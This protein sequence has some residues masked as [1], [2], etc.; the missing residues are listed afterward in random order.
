MN[1]SKKALLNALFLVITLGVNT[2]GAL[3]YINGLSQKAIS[4]MYITLITPSPSTFSIWG[5]IY[6]LLIVSI[7]VLIIKQDD[8]YY[9]KVIDKI[10][11]L[12]W[13][14]CLLN[15]AWIV[16][17]SYVL[18][19]VSLLFILLFVITL[20]LICRQLLQMQERNILLPLTFGLY[21]GWLFIAS[22]VNAAAVLVKLNWNGF[23]ISIE[24]LA[25]MTLV[26]SLILVF[27]VNT[28][29]KN[30]VFPLPV[31][32]AFFG[33]RE[34]LS[35]PNGFNGEYGLLQIVALVGM[36]VLISLAAIQF[37]INRFTLIPNPIDQ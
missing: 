8:I 31:A 4:D 15:I 16:S 25:I 18:L 26:I 29:L 17:F 13:F 3:G 5:I 2:L 28:Q 19:E 30:A 33:I 9:Q 24:I 36:A 7:I 22:V 1:K 35:S 10:S 37:Y 34:F 6:S 27:L 32:W 20:A 11:P 14:S 21:T 12:F 23:G